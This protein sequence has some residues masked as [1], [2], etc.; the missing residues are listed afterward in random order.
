[1]DPLKVEKIE[2]VTRRF[3]ASKLMFSGI[4][5]FTT[6]GGNFGGLELP[7]Y[8]TRRL[9][10][11]LRR[12]RE[13]YAPEYTRGQEEHPRIPDYRKVLFWDS[14]VTINSEKP[15]LIDFFTSDDEGEYRIEVNGISE[16]G[17]P[18]H[19]V[20]EFRVEDLSPMK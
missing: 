12:S 18:V 10:Q 3:V 9:Y 17:I 1:M 7:P 16:S 14:D 6:Y 11:G 15:L 5:N 4:I 19:S 13:F 2:I 20:S 8:V